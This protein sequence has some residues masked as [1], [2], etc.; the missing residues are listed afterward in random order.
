MIKRTF[1]FFILALGVIMIDSCGSKKS[2]ISQDQIVGYWKTVV[3]ENEYVQFEKADSEFVYSAFTYDRL[4]SSG[5]WE[6]TGNNLTLN[7]D[8]G[9]STTLGVGFNGDTMVFNNGAEK[10]VRAI[11]SGDGKT[12]VDDISDVEI[13]E[14]IIKNVNVVF[15]E[16]EPFNE[17]WVSPKVKWQKISTEVVLTK[18]GFTEL[19]DVAN[20][21]SKF[22]VAQG[23]VVDPAKTSEIISSYRKGNLS[24]LIR[25]RSSNE[26]TVGE[27]TYVDVISSIEK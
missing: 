7:F 14:Q 12:P 6:L 9:T 21:I 11:L 19:V 23:F 4:A 26:P 5:T 25:T 8:D 10:Y 1:T 3:G 27:T 13:L 16:T 24:V 2:T 20:Q 17:D 15:S 22:L 18:E